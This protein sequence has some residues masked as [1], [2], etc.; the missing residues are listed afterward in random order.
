MKFCDDLEKQTSE[1]KENGE[2]LMESVL[3]EVFK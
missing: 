2:R 1:A 3:G